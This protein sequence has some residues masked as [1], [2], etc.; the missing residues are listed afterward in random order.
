MRSSSDSPQ[1]A[2]IARQPLRAYLMEMFG[3]H[4][5]ATATDTA[6]DMGRRIETL[7]AAPSRELMLPPDILALYERRSG[8]AN[9][10]KMASW[11]TTIGLINLVSAVFDFGAMP[12]SLLLMTIMFR[13]I[14]TVMFIVC[15]QLLLQERTAPRA[16]VLIIP[17][18]VLTVV[19]AGINGLTSGMDGLFVIYLTMSIIIV[20]T[21]ITFVQFAQSQAVLLAGSAL[22]VAAGFVLASPLPSITEKLQLILFFT[23]VMGA[24][25]HARRLQTIHQYRVFLLQARDEMRSN[26]V[27]KKTEN[28]N[29]TAYTDRLTDV[30]NRRYFDEIIETLNADPAR[31]LPLALCLIDIDHFKNLND[32]L[33]SLQGDQCLRMIAT[34]M[35]NNLRAKGNILARFSEDSFVLVLMGIEFTVAKNILERIRLA[36]LDLNH[37]NPGTELGRVSVSIGITMAYNPPLKIESLL[38]QAE[39]AIYLA[40][41]DGRNRVMYYAIKSAADAP[42]E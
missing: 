31:A 6:G 3:L 11:C 41:A 22:V 12:G 18:C 14:I 37:P 40:K 17:A 28:V 2:G 20:Y 19:F 30:P 26:E 10:R 25:L 35:R 4:Q 13:A 33:G 29:A 8:R 16:A 42:A 24:L 39:G 38:Q 34:T 27:R 23:A 15:A 1:A 32:R 7:I 9:Q 21:A 36:I 5:P